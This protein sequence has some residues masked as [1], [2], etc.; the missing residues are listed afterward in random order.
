[1]STESVKE[2]LIDELKDLYSAENQLTKAL[3]KMAK[4]AVNEELK[5]GFLQHLEE[6][7]GHLQRL[8]QAFETAGNPGEGENSATP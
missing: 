4:A 2:L 8:E 5:A 7:K 1:M 6:T 3:P